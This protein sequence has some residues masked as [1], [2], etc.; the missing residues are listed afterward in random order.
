MWVREVVLRAAG[1]TFRFRFPGLG[2]YDLG[3]GG[4]DRQ[5]FLGRRMPFHSTPFSPNQVLVVW[6]LLN[7]TEAQI[8]SLIETEG[9]ETHGS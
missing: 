3:F 6:Q 1:K 8:H 9:E 5:Y 2:W 4:I 7:A